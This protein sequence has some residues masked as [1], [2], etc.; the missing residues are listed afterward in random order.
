MH[1]CP[2]CGRPAANE[3]SAF[4]FCTER[5][6]LLDLGNWLDERYAVPTDDISTRASD[7]ADV[8][9]ELIRVRAGRDLDD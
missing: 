8:E 9:G 3:G 7:E 2:I 5:C 6:R 1:P 4:P